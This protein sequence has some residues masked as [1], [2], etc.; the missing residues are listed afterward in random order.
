MQPQQYT[1][2]LPGCVGTGRPAMHCLTHWG[3]WV[4]EFL[5]CN[6]SELWGQ[7][8]VEFLHGTATMP[9]RSGQWNSCHTLPYLLGSVSTAIPAMQCLTSWG[10]WVVVQCT[11]TLPRGS[12]K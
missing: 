2:T 1:A 4:V 12:G 3:Q 6:A 11:P 9:G 7:W 5:L 8:A 10:N